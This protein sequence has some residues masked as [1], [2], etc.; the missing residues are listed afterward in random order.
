MPFLPAGGIGAYLIA[1]GGIGA[2]LI[3]RAVPEDYPE[4]NR[5]PWPA[6][7]PPA[8]TPLPI[9][10]PDR[11][12]SLARWHMSRCS[13]GA[14]PL[15][16]FTVPALVTT[17]QV[18]GVADAVFGHANR[19]PQLPLLARKDAEGNWQDVPAAR[20]RD[21]VVAV[22][23]GLLAQGVR[24]GDRVA[25]MSRTCYEW[26]LLDFALWTVGA[27]SIPDLSDLLG[28]AGG[29]DAVRRRGD[30]RRGRARGPRD[31]GRYR[32][33]PAAA[34]EE[35]VA[36]RLGRRTGADGRGRAHR[37]TRW[38]TGTATRSPRTRSRP[39]S[40][41]RAPP[42]APRAA[43]SPTPTSW[44]R[45]TTSSARYEPVFTP[46]P[47]NSRRT[48]LFLPLAHV[49][50]RMVRG[51]SVRG[52]VRF[53]HQPQLNARGPAARP[54]RVPA[55]IRPGGA[56]HLREDLQQRRAPQGRDGGQARPFEKA[57]DVA[58]R[59]A[60]AV[61][62]KASAPGPAPAPALRMQH[63]LYD[64]LVYSKLRDAMGGRCRHAMSGGSA[65]DAPARPVLRRRRRADLRGLRAHR[66]HG[67]GD[68][69]PARAHPLRHRRPAGA[70]HHRAHR[71]RRRDLAARRAGLPA[72]T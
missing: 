59:Y 36:A 21:E 69:Q 41:P 43:C 28:R 24:F 50:G 58:V 15:R 25:L 40:T 38:S 39:S 16:E 14:K 20:F 11:I 57:V 33:R 12:R 42:A 64:K 53:G 37:A 10:L 46:G 60:E 26:T 54:G 72:A 45:R 34:A 61:E 7:S 5:R 3:A 23:K 70:G 68:R 1:A 48:L 9:N 2:Y 56:V 18:G 22:A 63:Q 6:G 62:D 13:R 35:A 71:R 49:F 29:L 47:A 17:P 19:T 55:D 65:M 30:G 67:G 27:Q 31:D 66:D 4:A 52:R 51:R 44:P 32:G 8:A